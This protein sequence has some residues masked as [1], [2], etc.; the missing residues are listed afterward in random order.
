MLK[1]KGKDGKVNAMNS[2][3]EQF[4][5]SMP[6]TV[7]CHFSRLLQCHVYYLNAD[8]TV[9]CAFALGQPSSHSDDSELLNAL[10]CGERVLGRLDIKAT[11]PGE[12]YIAID[13]VENEMLYGRLAAGP[14]MDISKASKGGGA[15]E[16]Y[17]KA[18]SA[19][20]L[21]YH[22]VYGEWTD[23]KK[24]LEICIDARPAQ[25]NRELAGKR[26]EPSAP[27][28]TTRHHSIV[29]EN[30]LF[31]LISEGNEKKLL[32]IINT[33]PDGMYGLL[34]KEHPLRNL[35]NDCIC[36]I[37]LAARAAIAGGL[38][39]ETA[40]SLSDT[41][42]QNLEKHKD[43]DGLYR[44]IEQT[45][46]KYTQMVAETK[47]LNYSNRINRCRNYIINHVYDKLSVAEIAAYFSLSPEYLSEQFKRETGTR[48]IDFIQ[49]TRAQEAKKL[50]LFTDKSIL[51]IASLLNYHDQ[52][53][54]TKSFK[55]VFG[56]T[57]K[58]C[59]EAGRGALK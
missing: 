52:S 55:A 31:S 1:I 41:A 4:K 39:S 50:L 33:P 13:L 27:A 21:L 42:I 54:F 11:R 15:F 59:R 17:D 48:L 25:K 9:R 12:V 57:P 16:S 49:T 47:Q 3:S 24:L 38:D 51:E 37:T 56:I 6:S 22:F 53:H 32:E 18:V 29:F 8:N 45:L 10:F 14:I 23:E 19:A 20:I 35:K 28:E 36:I 5:R 30:Q 26:G 34:D 44:L 43:V 40:F 7:C 2:V 46:C 58:A